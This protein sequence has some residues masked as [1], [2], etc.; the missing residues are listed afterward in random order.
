MKKSITGVV[1]LLAGA[2]A[3]HSQGTV[4]FADYLVLPTYITVTLNGNPVG[5]SS[6]VTTGNPVTDIAN[7]GDWSVQ[8]YANTGSGD[9]LS[10]LTPA[11]VDG[12]GSPGTP[13]TATLAGGGTGTALGTWLSSTIADV[14]GQAT[15]GGSPATVAVAAWYNDGGTITSEAAAVAAH[16]PG[17]FSATGAIA[18][19]GGPQPSGPPATA[20]SLPALGGTIALTG[21]GTVTP[22]PSTIALGVMGASA[23]LMRLRK[24]S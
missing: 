3:A 9:A 16:L 5:G 15:V 8:L 24:K 19:T 12:S 1:A 23:F 10:T 18:S 7:G 13:V 22:E 6:T 11:I 4:S 21:S 17:G 2:F 20:P 14:P